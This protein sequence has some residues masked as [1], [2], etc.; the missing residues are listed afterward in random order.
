MGAPV[1]YFLALRGVAVTLVER[2]IDGMKRLASL[3][4]AA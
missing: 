3:D 4:V 2:R 1:G